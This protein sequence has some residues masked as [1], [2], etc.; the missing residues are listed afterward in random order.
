VTVPKALHVHVFVARGSAQLAGVDLDE[1]DAVRLTD[2]PEHELTASSP[3]TEIL[4]W[5]TN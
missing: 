4:V 3:D 2:E 5:A 1:G